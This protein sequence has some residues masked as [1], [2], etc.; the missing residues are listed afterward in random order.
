MGALPKR[1]L[2]SGD[3][4][5]TFKTTALRPTFL[6]QLVARRY[7]KRGI[8]LA[9]NKPYGAWAVPSRWMLAAATWVAVSRSFNHP[10]P[11]SF[12]PVEGHR[13]F[14]RERSA[15]THRRVGKTQLPKMRTVTFVVFV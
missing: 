13:V 8:I 6:F 2:L 4:R 10:H 5:V 15:P 1:N 7:E 3:A 12:G 9:S 14:Y 11:S